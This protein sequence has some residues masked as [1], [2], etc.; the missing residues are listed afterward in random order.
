MAIHSAPATDRGTCGCRSAG[1]RARRLRRRW[2]RCPQRH[3]KWGGRGRTDPRAPRADIVGEDAL[4]N[5][6]SAVARDHGGN[7]I[8]TLDLTVT[9]DSQRPLTIVPGVPAHLTL[10]FNLAASKTVNLL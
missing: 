5:A 1:P 9:L 8:G 3:R 4:G 6:V 7:P 2:R 10:A